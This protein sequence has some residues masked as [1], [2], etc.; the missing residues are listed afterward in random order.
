VVTDVANPDEHY[1]RGPSVAFTVAAA[2]VA[3]KKPFPWWI[4]ALAAGVLVIVVAVV[5]VLSSRGGEG[6]GLGAA[7]AKKDPKCGKDLTCGTGNVC[8]GDKGFK[9]DKPE[10]CANGRCEAGTCEKLAALGDTCDSADDCTQPL[11]CHEGACRGLAGFSPCDKPAQCATGRCQGNSCQ[12]QVSL[13][14]T[15][16]SDDDCRS[17]LTCSSGLCLIPVGQKCTQSAQCVTGNCESQVCARAVVRCPVACPTGTVCLNGSCVRR[18]IFVDPRLMRDL[19][20]QPQRT[21]PSP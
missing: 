8:L 16:D 11:A 18:D 5:A 3:A 1:D 14:D 17:P 10:Q 20:M 6:P 2:P 7:C 21:L 13:G 15:C 19:Q 9:C 4:V 12:E